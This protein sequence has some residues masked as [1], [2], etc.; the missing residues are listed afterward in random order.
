MLMP[1]ELSFGQTVWSDRWEALFTAAFV[2]VGGGLIVTLFQSREA[3]PRTKEELARADAIRRVDEERATALLEADRLRADA[4]LTSEVRRADAQ[5]QLAEEHDRRQQ[6]AAHEFQ[7]RAALRDAYAQLLVAQ[8]R[9][10]QTSLALAAASDET[11]ATLRQAAR[12]AHDQFID[13][14]HRLALDADRSMWL[15]LRELRKA[16]DDMLTT[17]EEG[18]LQACTRLVGTARARRQNLERS[19]RVRLGHEPLQDRKQTRDWHKT[20]PAAIRRSSRGRRLPGRGG[21][22]LRHLHHRAEPT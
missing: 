8:R 11:R 16:L 4:L 13:E 7:E 15:D 2:T 19:F 20:S 5:R 22:C 9:S 14:Y 21:G 1:M 12:E 10:R 6:H 17:A 18:D 3:A